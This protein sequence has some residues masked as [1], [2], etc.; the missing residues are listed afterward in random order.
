[1]MDSV[2][3]AIGTVGFPIVMALIEGYYI[4]T[5]MDKMTDVVS[6]NTE[7]IKLLY[8]RLGEE[9]EE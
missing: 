9:A 4:V 1:M 6:K 2:V 8:E 5:R 3:G 7:I